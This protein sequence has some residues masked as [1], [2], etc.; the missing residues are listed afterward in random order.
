M[1]WNEIYV[2][3]KLGEN[4]HTITLYEIHETEKNIFFVLEYLQG[5]TLLDYIL[6]THPTPS[7]CKTIIFRVIQ[8]LERIHKSNFMHRDVKFDNLMLG[9][10]GDITSL[11][12]IDFGLA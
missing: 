2:M 4:K 5:G 9:R 6:E 8:I 3:R 12:L 10:K 1:L 11:K 7:E